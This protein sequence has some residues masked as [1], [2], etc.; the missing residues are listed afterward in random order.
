[1][2][3]F[4]YLGI[5]R[6]YWQRL[7]EYKTKAERKRISKIWKKMLENKRGNLER[8]VE[9]MSMEFQGEDTDGSTGGLG[10]SN[11]QFIKLPKHYEPSLL[12]KVY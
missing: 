9:F 10:T 5:V 6:L 11:K 4:Y 7:V 1:M 2:F 12:S 3:S 8:G